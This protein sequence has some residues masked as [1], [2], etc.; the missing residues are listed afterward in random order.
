MSGFPQ[1][2]IEPCC[3][4]MTAP[5]NEEREVYPQGGT[6]TMIAITRNQRGCI[7]SYPVPISVL[8]FLLEREDLVFACWLPA[9]WRDPSV[10][11]S[12]FFSIHA[13]MWRRRLRPRNNTGTKA[14]KQHLKP[15]IPMSVPWSGLPQLQKGK[16]RE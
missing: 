4:V 7:A 1:L 13:A 2:I 5:Q 16:F 6:A 8:I 10:I 9:G 15:A 12:G 14:V 11:M 3:L